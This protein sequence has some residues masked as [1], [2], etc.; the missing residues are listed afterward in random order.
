MVVGGGHY[1]PA[2]LEN[3]AAAGRGNPARRQVTG[4]ATVLVFSKLLL[5]LVGGTGC[6][7]VPEAADEPPAERGKRGEVRVYVVDR[8]DGVRRLD[9]HTL[10]VVDT[11]ETGPRPHGIVGSPD[12]RFLYITLEA[13]NE[14]IKVDVKS[15]EIVARV[16]VGPIPN[17]PTLS[18]DG[19]YLF[20]PQRG[21]DQADVV[22][23]AI[24][25]ARTAAEQAAAQ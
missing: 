2:A 20:V 1:P 17:E 5:V 10:E 4:V 19:R 15:H 11:I 6:N 13:S 21:G 7:G 12:G 25:A 16:G 9:P 8:Y 24:T 14:V 23:T 18:L 22:D 3:A